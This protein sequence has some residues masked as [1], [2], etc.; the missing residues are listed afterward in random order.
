MILEPPYIIKRMTQLASRA[1]SVDIV[2][3]NVHVSAARDLL[4]CQNTRLVVGT[5]DVHEDRFDVICTN[6]RHAATLYNWCKVKRL[7]RCHSKLFIARKG[8]HDISAIVGSQN[9]GDGS[10]YELAYEFHGRHAKAFEPVFLRLWN[11]ATPVKPLDAKAVTHHLATSEFEA[12][13][14]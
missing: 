14:S 4:W 12:K 8:K 7:Q 6:A 5:P 1:D 10:F 13:A 3:Y 2:S 11:L 9:C